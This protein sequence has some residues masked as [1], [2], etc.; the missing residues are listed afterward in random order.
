M[1]MLEANIAAQLK[2]YL[3]NVKRL[4]ELIVLLDDSVKLKEM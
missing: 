4:I 1:T 3:D 2:T